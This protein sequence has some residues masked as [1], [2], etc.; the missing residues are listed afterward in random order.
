MRKGD[1]QKLIANIWADQPEG[2]NEH[3]VDGEGKIK[4][5]K[6]ML[7]DIQVMRDK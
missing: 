3:F 4:K 5:Q 2:R 6:Y 7:T 1:G